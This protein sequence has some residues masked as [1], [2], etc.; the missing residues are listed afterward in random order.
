MAAVALTVYQGLAGD[1][2]GRALVGARALGARLEA[3]LGVTATVVSEPAPVL[4]THWDV[5][6][7]AALGEL[8]LL[9]DDPRCCDGARRAARVRA[10]AVRDRDGHPPRRRQTPSRTCAWCGSTRTRI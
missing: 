3:R 9:A 6:L 2:N 7:A 5:E 1:H 10:H 4:D 8:R